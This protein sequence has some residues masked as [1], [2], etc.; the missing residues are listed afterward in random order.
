MARGNTDSIARL[1]AREL[2]TRDKKTCPKCNGWVMGEA[3]LRKSAV[4]CTRCD[5]KGWV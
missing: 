5:G 2:R 4:G 1:I 3:E